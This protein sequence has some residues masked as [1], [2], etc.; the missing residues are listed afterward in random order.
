M[1]VGELLSSFLVQFYDGERMIPPEILA[2]VEMEDAGALADWLGERAGRA[3]RIH[4]P[5]RG[6]KLRQVELA[7]RNAAQ[8]LVEGERERQRQAE[9]L[10]SLREKLGLERTPEVI[11][12]YD[13]S[14]FGGRET[15]GSR[16]T[17]AGGVADKDRYR[18][19]RVRAADPGD[20]FGALG[21]VLE[22][23]L[24]RGIAE[25]DLPDLMIIDGGKGQLARA[26]EVMARLN[27]VDIDVVGLAKARRK[28]RPSGE[29]QVSDE[30][31]VKHDRAE[32][33]VLKQ[34]S[35]ENHFLVRVRDEAHRFAI[36]YQRRLR[37]KKLTL[38]QL[39]EIPGIG[40]KRR[41]ALL[42]HLGS[43]E[44]VRGATL[45][46]LAAVPGLGRRAAER[47]FSFFHPGGDG[48]S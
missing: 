9:L 24:R 15:V 45:D 27:L 46:V 23:R 2:P 20:D 36:T 5:Q 19:Y 30:R 1:P 43:L 28:R 48:S 3:V 34:D 39:D 10:E 12:C 47:V 21:E 11:E 8:A 17:F 14:H 41:A 6:D 35:P 33:I 40:P 29:V 31:V 18:R 26:R 44:A 25:G 37:R 22:R 4:R 42:K 16:V 38:S 7:A 13:I 32:P